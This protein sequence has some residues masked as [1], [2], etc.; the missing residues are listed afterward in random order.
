MIRLWKNQSHT[1][2]YCRYHVVIVPKYRRKAIYGN[3]RREL[4]EILRELCRRNGVELVEGH[5]RSDHVHM[6]LEI[7]PKYAVSSVMGMLKGKSTI[8]LHQR[9]GRKRNFRGL[10]FWSRGYCVSSTGISEAKVLE[11][12]RSQEAGDMQE[13]RRTKNYFEAN[14]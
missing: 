13:E 1:R 11:Y 6:C 5:L 9:Y 7:P 8:L 2:W 4:G 12:I 3:M 10:N 14:N